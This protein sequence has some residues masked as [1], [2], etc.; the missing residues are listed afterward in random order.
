VL[1]AESLKGR[2]AHPLYAVSL[3]SRVK[4]EGADLHKGRIGWPSLADVVDLR[5]RG[6]RSGR[7]PP[8][9]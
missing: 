1:R 3:R 7:D 2:S 5:G 4:P 8:R 9:I 6:M